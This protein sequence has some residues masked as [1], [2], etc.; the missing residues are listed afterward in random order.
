MKSTVN[1]GSKEVWMNVSHVT[2]RHLVLQIRL[3]VDKKRDR[4]EW[5]CVPLEQVP[6]LRSALIGSRHPSAANDDRA[7]ASCGYRT[8]RLSRYFRG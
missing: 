7:S 8:I 6:D 5:V 2:E 1:Y 4:L 3:P